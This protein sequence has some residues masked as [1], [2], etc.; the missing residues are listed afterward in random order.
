[1]IK[2]Y[3]ADIG[4]GKQVDIKDGTQGEKTLIV[5]SLSRLRGCFKATTH[6]EAD[7]STI[8]EPDEDGSIILTDIVFTAEK[9]VGGTAT[10]RFYDGTNTVNIIVVDVTDSAVNMA[11]SLN[12][13]WQ[14]WKDARLELVT[15]LDFDCTISV[16]YVKIPSLQT[17]CYSAWDAR[18]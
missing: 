18:R 13:C 7:T 16:G 10:I 11:T 5:E 2:F 8:T 9:K 1:M 14:G 17:Q 12:G 15:V 4:T 3:L 6:T